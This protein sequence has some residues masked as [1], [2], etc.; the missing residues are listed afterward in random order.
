MVADCTAVDF[1]KAEST[2]F[3][4]QLSSDS[5]DIGWHYTSYLFITIFIIIS[6][7]T[8]WSEISKI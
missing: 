6:C 4:V 2:G 1:E 8:K 3:V 5:E 7:F